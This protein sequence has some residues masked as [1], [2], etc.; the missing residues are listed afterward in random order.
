MAENL[1]LRVEKVHVAGRDDGLSQLLAELDDGAVEAAQLLL[2]LGKP[3][4][5]HE[6]VVADGLN[7]QK[8]IEACDTLQLRPALVVQNRLEQFARLA[9]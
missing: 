2:V 4:V 6:A 9:G 8:V 1:I 3:L 7:L 5:E